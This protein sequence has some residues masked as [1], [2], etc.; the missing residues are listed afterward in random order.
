MASLVL[1]A[2]GG[3]VRA[4]DNGLA[5]PDWPRC[6]GQ[7]VPPLQ[8]GL[9]IEHTHRL[10]AGV[11]GLMVLALAAWAVTRYRH[12]GDILWT[13]VTALLAVVAQAALGAVVVLQLLRAELVTA[14]LAMAML[15]V[16][17][18]LYL[19]VRADEP[20]PA[21]AT[22]GRRDPR[23]ARAS[24]GVAALAFAQILVGGHV[25]GI[26]AGLAY[27]DFPLMGGRVVPVVTSAQ[28]LYH[29]V[30]RGLGLLLVVA[31]LGLCAAGLRE[32]RRRVAR[33]D[34]QPRDRWLVR[35]PVTAAFLV[36]VQVLLGVANLLDGLSWVSVIPHLAVASWIWAVLVM[37]TL[38]AYRRAGTGGS[39]QRAAHPGGPAP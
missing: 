21:R 20:V 7:W 36:A 33:G 15:V 11:V 5:C 19:V 24:A 18:L 30:H 27:T 26:G 3:A 39:I 9:W 31:V 13:S 10:A 38:L 16:A 4:T 32:R 35:L 34:W 25:T 12:R 6:R 22:A 37:T 17:C 29:A 28:E 8:P 23:F 1:V 14:H 2:L